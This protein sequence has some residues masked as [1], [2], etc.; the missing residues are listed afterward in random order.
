MTSSWTILHAT[1]ITSQ[2]VTLR[3]FFDIGMFVFS[4]RQHFMNCGFCVSQQN[5]CSSHQF[6]SY[7]PSQA[8]RFGIDQPAFIRP[9]VISLSDIVPVIR[10]YCYCSSRVVSFE[11]EKWPFIGP[12]AINLYRAKTNDNIREENVDLNMTCQHWY[13][14]NAVSV[15]KMCWWECANKSLYLMHI[16]R[17]SITTFL[18]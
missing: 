3:R 9:V 2:S 15:L 14:I 10:F 11:I 8:W 5:Y 6:Y 12:V 1:H 16:L 18:K 17:H 7:C 4:A 13:F